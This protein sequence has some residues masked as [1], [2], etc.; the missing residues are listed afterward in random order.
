MAKGFQ[1][2]GENQGVVTASLDSETIGGDHY[3]Y[4][5]LNGEIVLSICSDGT[6]DLYEYDIAAALGNKSHKTKICI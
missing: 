5:R 4:L 6:G 1:I 2:K 3:L